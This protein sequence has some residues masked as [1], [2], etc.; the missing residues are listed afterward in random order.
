[1]DKLSA[2]QTFCAVVDHGSFSRAAEALGI[3]KAR[4]SQRVS[5][6]ENELGVRLLHRTTRAMNLTDDGTAYLERC[7]QILKDIDELET[8]MLGATNTPHGYLR[9]EAQ[10]TICRW[11]LTPRLTDFYRR[12]PEIELRLGGHDRDRNLLEN[13]IDCA[14]RTGHLKDSSLIARHLMDVRV[15]LYASPSYLDSFGVVET[16]IL[17]ERADLI[18]HFFSESNT[19]MPWLLHSDESEYQLK[20]LPSLAFDDP[21]AAVSAAVAGGGIT[22]A[23]PFFVDHLIREG[24]LTQVLPAWHYMTQPVHIVYPTNRHLSARVRV[25]VDWVID[26]VRDG[27]N[28]IQDSQHNFENK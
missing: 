17:L 24:Q 26:M 16:P 21:D 6:L 25:F 12:Y 7:R 11:I 9:V 10:T 15:N 13:G 14:I 4:A 23:A 2:M 22:L 1:M 28:P 5:D 18:G 27:Q 3:P 8:V 19:V 20:Q